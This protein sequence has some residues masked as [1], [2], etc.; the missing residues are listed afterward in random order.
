MN[1]I[2]KYIGYGVLIVVVL[3]LSVDV[4]NLDEVRAAETDENEFD[5][6]EY[7][8]N[9]WE[10]QL[11]GSLENAVNL[12][13]L[14]EQ[15][16][17]NFDQTAETGQ[18]IGISDSRY[19]LV[20]DSGVIINI[21]EDQI[22]VEL[23]SSDVITL[24][25]GYIFGNTVRNALSEIE[26]GEFVNMTQFNRVSIEM[27]AIVENQVVSQ[28]Q[29]EAEVGRQVEFTGALSINVENRDLESL[30]IVPLSINFSDR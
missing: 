21:S 19:F 23:E 13:E 15:L 14:I 2:G 29:E 7:A 5:A 24:A 1:K 22:E 11:P 27:N 4:K 9:F 28:L 6:A 17:N 16:E 3:I 25:S 12:G 30:R 20:Q 8:Q 26:I 18:M 10:N